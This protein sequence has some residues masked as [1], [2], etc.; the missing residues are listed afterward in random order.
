MSVG[1]DF[2]VSFST[3]VFT[4]NILRFRHNG[5]ERA[6]V[7]ATHNNSP[8]MEFEPGN[9]L[10]P[11]R[12]ELEITHDHTAV[13]IPLLSPAEDLFIDLG[14][15]I[16]LPRWTVEGFMATYQYEGPLEERIVAS[17]TLQLSGVITAG[18]QP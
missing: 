13:P 3:L 17:A 1:T 16:G 11:G 5:I 6:I 2:K 14:A 8:A 7:E 4:F 12:L 9:L 10:N 18:T 15:G